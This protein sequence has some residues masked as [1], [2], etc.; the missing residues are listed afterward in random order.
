MRRESVDIDVATRIVRARN[1]HAAI[2]WK[3]PSTVKSLRKCK[4]ILYSLYAVQVG[5]KAKSRIITSKNFKIQWRDQRSDFAPEMR[6][7]A[8]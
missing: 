6:M 7:Q 3:F 2:R 4:T 8:R 1:I 5:D